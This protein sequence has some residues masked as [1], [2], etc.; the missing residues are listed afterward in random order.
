MAPKHCFGKLSFYPGFPKSLASLPN[1]PNSRLKLSLHGTSASRL[2]VER[3]KAWIKSS[4]K[5]TLEAPEVQLEGVNHQTKPG[6]DLDQ[7]WQW[8]KEILLKSSRSCG[9]HCFNLLGNKKFSV[10][11]RFYLVGSRCSRKG[12][13]QTQ[14]THHQQTQLRIHLLLPRRWNEGGFT[15]LR[16]GPRQF[17]PFIGIPHAFHP[18]RNSWRTEWRNMRLAPLTHLW[19][20]LNCHSFAS[21]RVFNFMESLRSFVFHVCIQRGAS[22][23]WT[24]IIS[25]DFS[26][27]LP[28]TTPSSE[29][30]YWDSLFGR[31]KRNA[32][33]NKKNCPNWNEK[34][35]LPPSK[36]IHLIYLEHS[37]YIFSLLWL[38]WVEKNANSNHRNHSPAWSP[39]DFPHLFWTR[40]NPE[41]SIENDCFTVLR[42]F[43]ILAR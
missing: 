29:P 21:F 31:H 40:I 18:Q 15:F 41:S 36:V 26:K 17:Q 9:W 11:C 3:C 27:R 32:L 43:Q 22:N 30:G 5:T 34:K 16:Q 10:F 1:L 8:K 24:K 13:Q 19:K 12:H 7:P 4:P 20:G 2:T 6:E 42:L 38:N 25:M 23:L 39:H 37:F 33:P 14:I 35:T 28:S